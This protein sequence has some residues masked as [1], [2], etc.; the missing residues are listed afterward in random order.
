MDIRNFFKKREDV[1]QELPDESPSKTTVETVTPTTANTAQNTTNIE[2]PQDLPKRGEPIKQ[3]KLV[4]YPKTNFRCFRSE[5]YSR[6]SWLLYSEERDAAYCYACMQFQP[7]GTKEVAFTSSGFKNWKNALDVRGF[8]RHEKSETHIRAMAL[9]TERNQRINSC[10]S[11]STLVSSGVLEK[12]R[13]YM[14]SIIEVIQF[15]VV[16]ELALRGNYNLEE[17]T[18]RGLFNKLFEYTLRKDKFLAECQIHIP[19]N[20]IYTSPEIQN[21]I[22]E[23]MA[24]MVRSN[25]TNSINNA[26][27]KWFTL[28]EDG[29]KDR[30]NRENVAIGIRYVKDGKVRES[31]LQIITKKKLD[32]NTFTAETLE[33]LQK[34]N[35][36]TKHLLSQCYDGASVMSGRVGGV[37]AKIQNKL[38]RTV[39]Y[40]HCFNHRLHLVVVK[41]V[42]EITMLNHFFDQC[43]LLHEFFHHAKVAEIYEGRTI[44]R[45]LEQR[46]SGHLTAAQVI[47]SNYKEILKTLQVIQK[48][49]FNGFDVAKSTG[50]Q[51]VIEKIEFRFALLLA[52]K[53]LSLLQA[54][55]AALQ[56][57][58]IGLT[59]ALS[60]IKSTVTEIRLLRT[61]KNYCSLLA[62]A[63][64]LLPD[65]NTENENPSISMITLSQNNYLIQ[66]Q[67][68]ALILI[69][70]VATMKQLIWYYQKWK[71][72]LK[73]TMD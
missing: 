18:E 64:Q 25:I 73:N 70:E 23:V 41:T 72:A 58:T 56:T 15:L 6:F 30:N 59:A 50:L 66:V 40:V 69:L 17:H 67:A 20:A 37:A 27:V 43:I 29:T 28:L 68:Q 57:R 47:L 42:S 26:D 1:L 54:A 55:D 44:G 24:E 4:N 51:V 9:W 8:S 2:V 65:A 33:V 31:L 3:T 5:W 46:W 71:D 38:Q 45:L 13:Y 19:R 53:I 60:I 36:D 63:K 48:G 62:D 21:E 7:H 35:I 61:E 32:A 34:N 49:N 39:P 22:I 52:N 10:T 11:V 14:K 12:H 16:N